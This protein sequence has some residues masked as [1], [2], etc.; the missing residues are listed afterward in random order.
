MSKRDRG[1]SQDRAPDP[2]PPVEGEPGQDQR[3]DVLQVAW[4]ECPPPADVL[5]GIFPPPAVPSSV[6]AAADRTRPLSLSAVTGGLIVMRAD[7]GTTDQARGRL[8]NLRQG[9]GTTDAAECLDTPLPVVGYLA[10]PG[11]AT[12]E[13][14][15]EV[16]IWAEIILVTADGRH[17][18]SGSEY[19]ARSLRDL[20]AVYG[21]APWHE[22]ITVRILPRKSRNKRTYHVLAVVVS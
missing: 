18:R 5:T 13:E 20:E 17:V 1:V 3:P 15:G 4:P 2:Y 21:P 8:H 12:D 11:E 19:L 9:V 22:P 14:T 10:Y 16:R 6:D 7:L